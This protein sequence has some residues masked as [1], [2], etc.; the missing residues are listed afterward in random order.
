[1]KSVLFAVTLIMCLAGNATGQAPFRERRF[2]PARVSFAIPD[3]SM[4]PHA[5]QTSSASTLGM[6]GAGLGAG[7]V[8]FVVGG[9]I[10]ARITDSE[11]SDLDALSGGITGGTIGE[12]LFLPL[13][14]HLANHSRGRLL[15]AMLAS[16]GIGAA[17]VS[18]AIATQD[19]APLP[20]VILVL[21]P[22]A[23]LI[24]SIAIERGGR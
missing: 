4:I 8:G 1:V 22:V 14:V 10:G 21:T 9:Y 18:L 16:L 13:G 6:V 7:L 20:G 11:N 19:A 12:S 15:P 3:T 2:A 24:T 5:P 17:G 23:Q